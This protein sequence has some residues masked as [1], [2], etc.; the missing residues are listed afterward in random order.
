MQIERVEYKDGRPFIRYIHKTGKKQG[1]IKR[2]FGQITTCQDCGK[3]AFASNSAIK[4]G[5][6]KFCSFKCRSRLENHPQWNNGRKIDQYGYILLKK[7]QHPFKN[8][9]GYV[10]EHR[11]VIEKQIGRYLHRWEVGHHINKIKDDNR[12]QNLMCFK[13]HSVHQKFE[14]TQNVNDRDIVFNGQ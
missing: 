14:T 9:D 11:L 2:D 13:N 5:L 12:P 10:R 3:K 4:K 6:G 1:C 7:P 8:S